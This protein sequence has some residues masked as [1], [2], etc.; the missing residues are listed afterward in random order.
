MVTETSSIPTTSPRT[1]EV[2][3]GLIAHF[4]GDAG[5][6]SDRFRVAASRYARDAYALQPRS[7]LLMRNKEGIAVVMVW[8][9]GSGIRSFQSFL[10]GSL[11]E[12]GLPHPRVEHF[13]A[14]PMVWDV[15]S[16]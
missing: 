2:G 3:V 4:D 16:G 9:A 15:A 8:P 7:V 12:L 13:R 11:D 5:D 6:L 10:R 14:E 1:A